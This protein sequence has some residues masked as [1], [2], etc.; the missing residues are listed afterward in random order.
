[1]LVNNETFRKLEDEYLWVVAFHY[2]IYR[3]YAIITNTC[4]WLECFLRCMRERRL[5][6]GDGS[7]RFYSVGYCSLADLDADLCLL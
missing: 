1:M 3:P 5:K 2:Q 7:A 4:Q 6:S